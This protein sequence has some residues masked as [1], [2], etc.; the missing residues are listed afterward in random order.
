MA[1]EI[2]DR[3]IPW[4]R[5]MNRAV[6]SGQ[7]KRRGSRLV[8]R[9]NIAL[10]WSGVALLFVAAQRTS[11]HLFVAA[12]ICLGAV[13]I[14]D[15]RQLALFRR[16]RGGL[17]ATGAAVFGILYYLVSGLAV[18]LGGIA[19]HLLGEPR[20]DPVTLA[21]AELGVKTWPPVP[22]KRAPTPDRGIPVF[23]SLA[24]LIYSRSKRVTPVQEVNLVDVSQVI[25]IVP[26]TPLQ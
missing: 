7:P 18:F 24:A 15:A 26:G 23:D 2:F 21:F 14:N 10:S 1:T 5:L 6:T 8:A 20:P 25:E 22:S 9:L 3:A 11:P 13:V 19:Q 16:Q 4:M 17:F 12:A